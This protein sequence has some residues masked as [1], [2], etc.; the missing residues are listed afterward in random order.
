MIDAK[1]SENSLGLMVMF[2]KVNIR[3]EKKQD[4]GS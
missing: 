3:K 1:V 2:M 4:R